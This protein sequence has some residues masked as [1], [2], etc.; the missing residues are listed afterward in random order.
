MKRES[1]QMPPKRQYGQGLG[2][3][4]INGDIMDVR[5][6]S[7]KIG[8]TEKSTRALVSRRTIPFRRLGGRIVFLRHE[9][10]VWLAAL[11][12]CTVTEAQANQEARR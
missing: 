6:V 12:G 4:I 10:D 9:I 11:P 1:I 7:G 5:A 2:P 8:G 3:R